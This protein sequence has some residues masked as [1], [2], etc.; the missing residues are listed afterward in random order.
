MKPLGKACA[1]LLVLFAVSA[2][3]DPAI[4]VT[5]NGCGLLDGDGGQV[6]SSSDKT[7]F[8]NNGQGGNVTLK[9]Y[10]SGVA[11]STGKAVK[12]NF[13]NTGAACVTLFG[14]TFNWREVVDSEGD[15]VLTCKINPSG[16]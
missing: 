4:I 2:A 1:S 6:F 7:V 9:C 14:A 8:S 12:W 11:N 5:D 13:D 16:S 10:L 3:A 15:A